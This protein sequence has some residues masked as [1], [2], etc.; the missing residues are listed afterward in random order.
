[1]RAIKFYVDKIVPRIKFYK[2][3]ASQRIAFYTDSTLK[4]I[5]LYIENFLEPIYASIRHIDETTSTL[6][7]NLILFAGAVTDSIDDAFVQISILI[8]MLITHNDIQQDMLAGHL[9]MWAKGINAYTVDQHTVGSFLR[10]HYKGLTHLDIGE[11]FIA[12]MSRQHYKL[13]DINN[14]ILN[15]INSKTLQSIAYE[16]VE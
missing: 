14:L 5:V 9:R 3:I 10:V 15:D 1:M 16:E 12:T 7:A 8:R 13:K 6:L 2:D 11:Q 4:R